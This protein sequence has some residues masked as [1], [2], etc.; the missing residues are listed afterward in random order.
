MGTH[1]EDFPFAFDTTLL[2]LE[3]TQIWPKYVTQEFLPPPPEPLGEFPKHINY[4]LLNLTDV[5][6]E[7]T[8]YSHLQISFWYN[9]FTDRRRSNIMQHC[10][11]KTNTSLTACIIQNG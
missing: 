7:C 10:L 3:M 11:G 1:Y 9:L 4:K 5:I 2:G 8:N 6:F